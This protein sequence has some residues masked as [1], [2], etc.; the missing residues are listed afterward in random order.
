MDNDIST[1]KIRLLAK[2]LDDAIEKQNVV[3]IVSYFSEE[4]EIQLPGVILTGHEGLKKAISWMYK[5]LK[6]IILIPVTIMIQDNVFFEE[7]IVK[8][9]VNGH[10]ME[11]KQAEVLTYEKDY[12]VKSIRLY[13][14]RLEFGQNVSRNL[15]DL[16]L[17]GKI[18]KATLE[19]LK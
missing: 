19:G 13:F 10:D 6:E 11:I 5:Y 2:A 17:I 3:K 16:I 4:C 14:D 9:R 8:T 18:N 7:F 1:E 12:K 15:I